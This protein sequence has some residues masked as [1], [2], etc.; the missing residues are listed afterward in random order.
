MTPEQPVSTPE[1]P[2]SWFAVRCVFALG[3][4]PEAVGKTYEER[5]TLWRAASAEEAMAR[6]EAE[7]SEY[8]ATIT[9]A[10]SKVL[11]LVQSYALY[12]EPGDGAEVFSLLRES[13]ISPKEYIDAFFDTGAERQEPV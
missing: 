11:G 10:P 3:W 9:D 4:P 6:A 7:A 13:D 12:D 1:Q 8:A 2:V 5:I